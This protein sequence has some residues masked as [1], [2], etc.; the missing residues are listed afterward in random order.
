[1][2]APARIP[3]AAGKKI[4]KTEKNELRSLLPSPRKPGPKLSEKVSPTAQNMFHNNTVLCWCTIK[5]CEAPSNTIF[6]VVK[7][8]LIIII[9]AVHNNTK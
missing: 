3:V 4:E 6:A 7:T 8:N 2:L 9:E 1:M 5:S